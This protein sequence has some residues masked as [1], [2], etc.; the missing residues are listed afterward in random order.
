[1]KLYK[2]QDASEEIAAELEREVLL[3]AKLRHKNIVNFIGNAR[4]KT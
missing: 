1:M 2:I 4:P 3:L